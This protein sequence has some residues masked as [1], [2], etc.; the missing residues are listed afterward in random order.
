MP[1][2]LILHGDKDVL[3]PVS[4][5]HALDELLTAANRPHEMHIYEGANHA[6]NFPQLPFWYNAEDAH[7]AWNRSL[8]FLAANLK[9]PDSKS[10][11]NA[12]SR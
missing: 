6:F 10:A 5:A 4:E 12:V 7:D 8:Q 1:P 2:T 3:V 9:N 11:A